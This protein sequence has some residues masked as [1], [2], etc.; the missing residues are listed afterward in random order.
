MEPYAIVT[1]DMALGLDCSSGCAP[2]SEFSRDLNAGVSISNGDPGL[3][4]SVEVETK[5]YIYAKLSIGA[6]I[7]GVPVGDDFDVLVAER[8]RTLLSQSPIM[9]S[10]RDCDRVQDPYSFRCA[11]QVHG[12][13]NESFHR[14]TTM[15]DIELNSATDNPLKK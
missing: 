11:P 9:E 8:L 10:H 3:T 14:L 13:V 5:A 7:A 1:L 12:A 2:I 15:L 4:S 6:R